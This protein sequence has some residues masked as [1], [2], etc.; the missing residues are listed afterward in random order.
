MTSGGIYGPGNTLVADIDRPE[1]D[2]DSDDCDNITDAQL[3]G[4][5]ANPGAYTVRINATPSNLS[6]VLRKEP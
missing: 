1:V 4:I 6:G 2:Q 5:K 3:D